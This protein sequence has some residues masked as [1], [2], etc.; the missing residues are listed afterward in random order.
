MR[1]LYFAKDAP[2]VNSGY[3]KCCREICT[4]LRGLG[5]EVAIFATVGNKASFL[6]E[7]KGIPIYPGLIIFLAKILLLI[8]LIIL[9]LTF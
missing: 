1:I 3:G 6:F 8:T 7:Y 4:R 5:H 9:K 2:F